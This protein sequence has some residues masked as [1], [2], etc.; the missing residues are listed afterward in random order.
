MS[1]QTWIARAMDLFGDIGADFSKCRKYRFALWRIW[2]KSKDKVMFIG[3]NP[4]TANET[5]SDPTLTRVI[6]FGKRLGYGGVYMMNCFPWVSTD[7]DNLNVLGFK[8]YNDHMLKKVADECKD[9]IFAWGAF[10]VVSATGRDVELCK[11]FPCAKALVIN[12]DGS[13]RHPLYVN[14][15]TVP[16]AFKPEICVKKESVSLREPPKI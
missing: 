7:P 10:K 11:L 13:P 2:D 1:V 9:V 5:E 6:A 14:G 12:K 16:V 3:L 15:N 8:E 4:S